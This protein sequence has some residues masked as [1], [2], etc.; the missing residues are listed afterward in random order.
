[1]ES[2]RRREKRKVQVSGKSS[3]VIALPKRWASDMSLQHGD[4]VTITRPG[5]N[6]LL[7]VFD[8]ISRS[9]LEDR[10]PGTHIE[11]SEADSQEVILR[12]IEASYVSG[13]STIEVIGRGAEFKSREA[14]KERARRNLLGA[15][16]AGYSNNGFSL[17]ILLG[18]SELKLEDDLKRLY[19]VCSSVFR[20]A[21]WSLKDTNAASIAI[22]QHDDAHRLNLYLMRRL[23]MFIKSGISK[24]DELGQW[25]LLSFIV[26]VRA[27]QNL[28]D[29][30]TEIAQAVLDLPSALRN[31]CLNGVLGLSELAS[32]L[33]EESFVAVL[34]MDHYGAQSVLREAGAFDERRKEFQSLVFQDGELPI[35]AKKAILSL[36]SS[37]RNATRYARNIVDVV[38]DLNIEKMESH[39]IESKKVQF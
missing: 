4:E 30:S 19:S 13:Y 36:L 38:L 3:F 10:E 29:E 7:L 28:S 12:R 17:Q 8:P 35:D 37:L 33:V 20:E 21:I 25:D 2:F 15:E 16:V 1:M 23:N 18:N 6:S 32:R 34:K 24:E 5:I 22:S 27:L 14:V 31:D 39:G 11:V 9:V 26:V